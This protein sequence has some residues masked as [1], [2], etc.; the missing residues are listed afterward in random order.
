[1]TAKDFLDSIE[2]SLEG[3]EAC[4]SGGY[5]EDCGECPD[6]LEYENGVNYD[7]SDSDGFSYSSCDS[8]GSTL[9]GDRSV[10]HGVVADGQYRGEFVHMEWC[11]DC[12]MYHANGELPENL[13]EEETDD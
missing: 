10:A 11:V 2:A 8:C 9:G 4:S 13:E 6:D 5:L 7:D 1:M 3:L 12:V